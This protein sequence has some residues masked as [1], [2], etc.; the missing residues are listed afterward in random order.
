MKYSKAKKIVYSVIILAMLIG[1]T[2]IAIFGI[3]E[4]G[5]G[6]AKD[7]DLGLDLA[8]G[9]SITYEIQEDNPSSQDIKDTIAKLEKR[10]E[11]KSTES[12]VYPAGEKR[13]TVEIPGVTD[14]NAI[15]EELG[16]PGSLEF[17]DSTGYQAW[18]QGE[19]Y[20]PLLTGSD[21]Q[22]AQAYTDTSS[23]T[24]TSF[25]VQLTF[26]DE[27]AEKFE[28]ATE[29]NLGSIIY[30]VYDGQVIS[31]P[32]VEAVISGGTASI[33]NT[34]SFEAADNLAVFIRIGSIP[35]TLNE[36]SSNVV[37][38]QLGHNAIQTSFFAAAVGLIVLCIFMIVS[39]RMPGVVATLALWIYTALVLILVSVYD[40]TLTLP[41]LAGIILGI[42]MAVDANVVIYSRIREE[43]GAG[44]SVESSIQAGYEKATSAIVD[45]N[46]TTLIAAAVL[47]IFGTG[48]IKGF[49]MTL[50][51]G[52]VVSMFTALVITRVIMKLFYNFGIT[53]PKW[54]GKTVHVRKVNFLG[55]RKWC[56]IGSAIV[57]LA[58]FVGMFAFN[59][60]GKRALNYSLEFVGG[61]TTTY[62]FQQEYSQEQIEN[63]IIPVIREAAGITEVQQQKVKD[64]TKVTFKTTDLSLEQRQAAEEAVTAKFPIEEGSIVESDTI[65]SSVSA[66]MKQS[67][68]ISVV[69]ATLCMLL[70]IFIR[71]RDIKFAL[72][73]VIALVHDVLVVLTFYALARI[74]VGTTFIACMLTIVGYSINSTIII[75]DRIRELLKTSTKKT[76]IADLVNAAIGNTFT[77]TFNS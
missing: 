74:S 50:A 73:A 44:R 10:V 9:V 72:A 53:D 22:G 30:I 71:F 28:Q 16:T 56:F 52:I 59:A 11:G 13:I 58:G 47:Y 70:Y 8:G 31:Y 34:E 41:G 49:A 29:D 7:I 23:S 69:I 65:G 20:T 38:A 33:T 26:T 35:L 61:T 55:I 68:I 60:A 36:V 40:I 45:G 57:I 2:L 6:S 21:V 75:F 42:G 17:L 62:T 48:P 32:T 18:S 19:D 25:G 15:L 67:A 46:I 14:A 64:S 24:T 54:Y 4:N 51:L 12:Q 39:Y 66:T 76:N 27:G 5:S 63:E 37:A 77:R 3:D 1:F 43:I